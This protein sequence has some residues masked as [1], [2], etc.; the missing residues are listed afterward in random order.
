MRESTLSQNMSKAPQQRVNTEEDH[1]NARI[2][3]TQLVLN[4]PLQLPEE[5]RNVADP[6]VKS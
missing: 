4:S 2:D 1:P 3:I 6:P 5:G